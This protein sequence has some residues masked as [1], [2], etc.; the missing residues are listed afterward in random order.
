MA[1]QTPLVERLITFIEDAYVMEEQIAQTLRRHIEQATAA[2]A[3]IRRRMQQHLAETEV[4]AKRM[5]QRLEAHGRDPSTLKT[6]G[7]QLVGNVVGLMGALRPDTLSRNM[8][9]DYVT[10]HLEIAAY[11][12]L[13]AA[14]RAAGDDATIKA[15]EASLREEVLMADF[16]YQHLPE[17]L[18]ASFEQEGI[19]I[20]AP[21]HAEAV[22]GP[23]LHITFEPL[24][25]VQDARAASK[26]RP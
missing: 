26:K 12:M 6:T 18:F 20:P 16:L 4:Q 25:D 13:I 21:M 9:D 1:V 15:A 23:R 5:R 10:E 2:P 22:R 17:G 3:V 11:T 24:K 19:P 7:G 14:A 8:R